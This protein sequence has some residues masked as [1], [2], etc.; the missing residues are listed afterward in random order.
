MQLPPLRQQPR[1]AALPQRLTRLPAHYPHQYSPTIPCVTANIHQ[2]GP[3]RAPSL[4][5]TA[6]TLVVEAVQLAALPQE[7][8]LA[9]H[10]AKQYLSAIPC[11]TAL[12]QQ[13]PKGPAALPLLLQRSLKQTRLGAQQASFVEA[14]QQSSP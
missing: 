7:T 3:A 6:R 11:V 1:L 9:P 5:T 8:R 4:E 10:H 12:P 14:A 2:L 13:L